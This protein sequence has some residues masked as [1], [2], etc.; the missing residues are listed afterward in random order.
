MF[1]IQDTLW[2]GVTPS[3]EKQ[4]VYSAA[5]ADWTVTSGVNVFFFDISYA[6]E[7]S[8]YV[9]LEWE[10]ELPFIKCKLTFFPKIDE[11]AMSLE[12][13]F[14]QITPPQ[15][16]KKKKKKKKKRKKEK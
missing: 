1:H 4:S 8:V 6:N 9:E 7:W 10:S 15:K 3:A 16:K 11:I 5:P 2:E 12:V 14:D 13:Y